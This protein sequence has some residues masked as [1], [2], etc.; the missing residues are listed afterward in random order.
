MTVSRAVAGYA[1]SLAAPS[2]VHTAPALRH[3]IWRKTEPG[4]RLVRLLEAS[5]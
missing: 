3:A 1:V 4:C 2:A 5:G